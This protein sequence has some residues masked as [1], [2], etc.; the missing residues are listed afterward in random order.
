MRTRIRVLFA[1]VLFA[2]FLHTTTAL[3][4]SIQL[5]PYLATNIHEKNPNNN[6]GSGIWVRVGRARHEPQGEEGIYGTIRGVLA[7][8]LA[9]L[10][11][12][13]SFITSASLELTV[14]DSGISLGTDGP[15]SP[16]IVELHQIPSTQLMIEGTHIVN[17]IQSSA[18]DGV[19]WN[20]VRPG[21]SWTS[22]GGDFLPAVLSS[23]DTPVI[24]FGVQP[25]TITFP[26]TS[27]FVGVV[28][29]A[30]DGSSP[31]QLLLR[32]LSQEAET[33]SVQN[34]YRFA[35]DDDPNPAFYPNLTI[36]Y[37]TVS[38]PGNGTLLCVGLAALCV[39]FR[40]R[41]LIAF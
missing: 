7:F 16:G 41:T 20:E 8:D 39:W 29:S 40:R 2:L 19:T 35:S 22:P 25:F 3:A 28:Q 12:V 5:I 4:D 14:M 21:V 24:G 10:V 33:S 31:L 23:T 18:S 37:T 17:F 9:G 36:T 13:G 34:F 1:A 38:E 26:S 27:H 30:L 11:P 15:G 32:S 6:D